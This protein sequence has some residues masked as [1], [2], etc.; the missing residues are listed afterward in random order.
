MLAVALA[1]ALQEQDLHAIDDGRGL[2]IPI[3]MYAFD[4][5]L[6]KD[7]EVVDARLRCS[8]AAW[9][10]GGVVRALVLP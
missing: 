1:V 10:S 7:C 8:S 5:L 6:K 2:W 9:R 3:V 4:Y